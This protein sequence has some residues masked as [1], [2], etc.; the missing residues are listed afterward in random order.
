MSD[1]IETLKPTKWMSNEHL[2]PLCTFRLL[3]SLLV[4]LFSLS[5]CLLNCIWLS[6]GH[7]VDI[8]FRCPLSHLLYF[9]LC[10]CVRVPGCLCLFVFLAVCV[11]AP[12]VQ[13]VVSCFTYTCQI[14]CI[15][16]IMPLTLFN[17]WLSLYTM[18]ALLACLWPCVVSKEIL[19]PMLKV[20]EWTLFQS[21]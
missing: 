5:A 19:N 15:T 13:I 18:Y 9:V 6:V 17:H 14:V 16:K 12:E 10:I 8:I 4:C 11:P 7:L 3:S 21:L 20:G 2:C 1:D